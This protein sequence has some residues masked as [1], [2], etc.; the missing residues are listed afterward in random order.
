MTDKLCNRYIFFEYHTLPNL[1]V[2]VVGVITDT[3][4]KAYMSNLPRTTITKYNSYDLLKAEAT[5]RGKADSLV[6]M[7]T[8]PHSSP[9]THPLA[10]S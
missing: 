6:T 1:H 7:I 9:I 2:S 3:V 8:S 5:K 4:T 10:R